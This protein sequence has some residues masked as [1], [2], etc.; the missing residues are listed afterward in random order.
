VE[1]VGQHPE[2]PR[3]RHER[4]SSVVVS[5]RRRHVLRWHYTNPSQ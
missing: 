4:A 2:I 3:T 1:T 5:A